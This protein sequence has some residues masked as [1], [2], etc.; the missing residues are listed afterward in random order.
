MREPAMRGG[1]N[2]LRVHFWG[3]RGSLPSPA[4][5]VATRAKV[6][7]ALRL[8][9]GRTLET[10]ADVDA[11]LET[12]PFAI[13]GSYGGNTSCVEIMTGEEESLICDAGSGLRVFGNAMLARHGTAPRVYHIVMSHM[14]WDHIMGFPFFTPAYLPGNRI[15]IYGCHA[16]LRAAFERQHGHPSFPVPW[17]ALEAS[18]EFVTLEPGVPYTIAGT[19]VI[20]MKQIHGGDS[21]GYR[22]ERNGKTIVYSTDSEHTFMS[23]ADQQPVVELFR[24]ADV[25]IFDAM[26]SLVETESVKKNWGHSSNV[27]GVELAHAA[28]AKH[29]VLYHHEPV[30]DDATIDRILDETRHFEE[31]TRKGAPL[32][33]TAAYDGLEFD[34]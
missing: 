16:E 34:A 13:A 27:L 15:V 20:A 1:T 31:I 12:M 17:T 24:D 6:R 33:V 32:H 2:P 28:D 18:I 7:A 29:L 26:Y 5:A 4:D 21:F 10:D 11:V 14:H 9:R 19:H 22:F 3:T 30:H 23:A 8:A 25:V